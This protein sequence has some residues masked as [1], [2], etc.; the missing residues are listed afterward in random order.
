LTDLENGNLIKSEFGKGLDISQDIVENLQDIYFPST[1]ILDYIP[2]IND[3]RFPKS[4]IFQDMFY[5]NYK[6][7][8]TISYDNLH[9]NLTQKIQKLENSSK[10]KPINFKNRKVT[11]ENKKVKKCLEEIFS[12][13]N[14]NT[15]N[16]YD[17]RFKNL[18]NDILFHIYSFLGNEFDKKAMFISKLT[19]QFYVIKRFSNKSNKLEEYF[20]TY[21]DCLYYNPK[22]YIKTFSKFQKPGNCLNCYQE[23]KKK[24]Y[25]KK[26]FIL[27]IPEGIMS[28]EEK[29]ILQDTSE[30]QHFLCQ[31]CKIPVYC[32]VCPKCK[33]LKYSKYYQEKIDPIYRCEKCKGEIKKYNQ[34]FGPNVFE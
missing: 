20:R 22:C 19:H 15:T 4:T 7:I 6:R 23:L 1:N 14:L 17:D 24:K 10:M 21:M 3:I 2:D 18:D 12:S 5:T 16:F 34:I 8:Y 25:F 30:F 31:N 29:N 9:K 33:I 28:N 26:P 27:E 13:N 11:H 32:V